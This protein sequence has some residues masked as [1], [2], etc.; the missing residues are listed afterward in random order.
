MVIFSNFSCS[1]GLL[2][3]LESMNYIIQNDK[4]G[5]IQNALEKLFKEEKQSGI[6]LPIILTKEEI[7][8]RK[9]EE[10]EH[11]EKERIE[12]EKREFN[13]IKNNSSNINYIFVGNGSSSEENSKYFDKNG[14]RIDA[15][16][17]NELFNY[18]R[19]VCNTYSKNNYDK[20]QA[21]MYLAINTEK[22]NR[23]LFKRFAESKIACFSDII[24]DDDL[25]RIYYM[26]S[27]NY[28]SLEIFKE[29]L[30]IA[31]KEKEYLISLVEKRLKWLD[32]IEKYSDS[33]DSQLYNFGDTQ[34]FFKCDRHL[35]DDFIT[36]EY[37][38]KAKM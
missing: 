23:Y 1:E 18:T 28:K 12:R 21:D 13:E 37:N 27:A 8:R 31:F 2:L 6:E 36:Y 5:D 29:Y 35:S 33:G 24:T 30:L 4:H 17:C 25:K 38:I 34:I 16:K 3:K 10:E 11:I 7:E 19:N 20:K 9:K 15:Y 22:G 26:L 32:D 14:N